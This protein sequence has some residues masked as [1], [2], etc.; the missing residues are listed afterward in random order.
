MSG[1]Y[2]YLNYEIPMTKRKGKHKRGKSKQY[3]HKNS[4]ELHGVPENLY[5][6]TEE[7]VIKLGLFRE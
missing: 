3:T 2:I 4:L 1:N 7:V 5:T 6:S